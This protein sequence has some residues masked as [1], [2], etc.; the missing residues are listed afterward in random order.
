MTV[1][2]YD[3]SAIKDIKKKYKPR[4]K[5]AINNATKKAINDAVKDIKKKNVKHL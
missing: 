4:I 3:I 5:K 2:H 1:E